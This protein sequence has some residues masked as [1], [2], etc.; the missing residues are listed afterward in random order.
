MIKKVRRGISLLILAFL[1]GFVLVLYIIKTGFH[2]TLLVLIPSL[3]LTV[4]ASSYMREGFSKISSVDGYR[5]GEYLFR[6]SALLFVSIILLS[7]RGNYIIVYYI[8][9]VFSV[10]GSVF[11]L[12][13]MIFLG[14][15]FRH[16]SKLYNVKLPRYAGILLEVSMS[17]SIFDIGLSLLMRVFIY[18]FLV[19]PVL[20]IVSLSLAYL[21]LRKIRDQKKE[22]E[23]VVVA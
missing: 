17:F 1:I 9:V 10:F 22:D 5:G 7:A 12:L 18:Y 16:I 15:S 6:Y 8:G 21:G 23:E 3:I 19:L 14:A 13:G 2:I 11:L 20:I 4:L